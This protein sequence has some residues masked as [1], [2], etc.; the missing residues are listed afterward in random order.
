MTSVRDTEDIVTADVSRLD[1]AAISPRLGTGPVGTSKSIVMVPGP[2]ELDPAK[3]SRLDK[4]VTRA[5]SILVPVALIGLWQLSAKFG[6]IDVRFFPAPT[7]I[8]SD[9]R[10]L[11]KGG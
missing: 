4:R 7:K 6:W 1:S 11:F 5:L 9:W 3:S 10:G 2:R 8:L